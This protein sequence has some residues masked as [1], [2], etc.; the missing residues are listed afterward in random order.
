MF[1]NTKNILKKLANYNIKKSAAVSGR[2]I[3]AYTASNTPPDLQL[4]FGHLNKEVKT[5]LGSGSLFGP[6]IYCVFSK[7][8]YNERTFN[9]YYGRYIYTL[10]T[11]TQNVISFDLKEAIK[12]YPNLKDIISKRT[13]GFINLKNILI[14]QS[15]ILDL[16][17]EKN[18]EDYSLENKDM[19][20]IL[21]ENNLKSVKSVLKDSSVIRTS[22]SWGIP[23]PKNN[24][25]IIY[26]LLD[27]LTNSFSV[28]TAPGAECL[29]ISC[30]NLLL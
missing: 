22:F 26:V 11:N 13:D 15:I 9:G 24:K 1:Y 6:G 29:S 28:D 8:S 10:V 19:I 27:A 5:G 7:D 25:H 4:K 16:D 2:F 18:I 3:L 23:V 14:A 17:I 30:S 12:I 21:N 20:T